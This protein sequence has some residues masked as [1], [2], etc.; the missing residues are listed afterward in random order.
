MNE[1][2]KSQTHLVVFLSIIELFLQVFGTFLAID[3]R[4]APLY[5]AL[6]LREIG[7]SDVIAVTWSASVL[8][9]GSSTG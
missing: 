8:T 1:N 5:I 2:Q 6:H 3:S 7:H 4:A 9:M